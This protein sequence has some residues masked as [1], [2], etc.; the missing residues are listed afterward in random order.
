MQPSLSM[1]SMLST[2]PVPAA[3]PHGRRRPQRAG[4]AAALLVVPLVVFAALHGSAAR[5]QGQSQ[6]RGELLY[7]MSCVACHNEKMHWRGRKLVYDWDSL[8]EQVRRWQQA[9]ALNWRDED[10]VEVARYLNERFY[11]FTPTNTTGLLKSS[12]P[13]PSAASPTRVARPDRP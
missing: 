11:G 5:A 8:E 9:S 10:I 12:V 4:L 6:S 7:N 13:G 1:L 3:S 2:H